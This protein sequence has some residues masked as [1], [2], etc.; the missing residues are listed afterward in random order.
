METFR[1]VSANKNPIFEGEFHW[2]YQADVPFEI[3]LS[4]FVRRGGFLYLFRMSA[5][6]F[7]SMKGRISPQ[8]SRLSPVARKQ[9]GVS[10]AISRLQV[11]ASGCVPR[12]NLSEHPA[13]PKVAA[14]GTSGTGCRPSCRIG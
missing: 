14:R 2:R 8:S 13:L 1:F 12:A 6:D 10:A 3:D 7:A 11:L 9:R 5:L 4:G